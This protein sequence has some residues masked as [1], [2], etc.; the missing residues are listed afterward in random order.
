MQYKFAQDNENYEEYTAGSVFYALPGYTAFPVRLTNEVFQRCMSLWTASGEARPCV[1]YDPCCGGAYLL[2][3]LAY[4]NWHKIERIFGSD[5][6]TEA[7]SLANRNLSLLQV[8]G[9]DKRIEELSV[10][11]QQFGKPSHALA[12]KNAINFR[13]RL[14][15]YS[16]ANTIETH[17][18][19]ADV[20]N[21]TAI[22][23]ELNGTK[24]DIVITDIPYGQRSNWDSD[25]KTSTLTP[26]ADPVNQMLESLLPVLAPKAI[27]A[28]AATKQVTIQHESYQ[29][30]K[31]FKLGK[32]QVVF[33]RAKPA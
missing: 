21:S 9:L 14:L 18:F 13:Q 28:V 30:L 3:T 11:L 29:Q 19:R 24:I 4:L 8:R 7:L 5:I 32:R 20:R 6:D 16:E 1:L 15:E 25:L 23:S 17:L 10:M 26:D 2:T 31:K 12:L 22:L 33:L 27:V